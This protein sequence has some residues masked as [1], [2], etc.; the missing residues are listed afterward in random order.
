MKLIPHTE[1]NRR[2]SQL[3]VVKSHTVTS[4]PAMRASQPE[5]VIQRVSLF[6]QSLVHFL[7]RKLTPIFLLGPNKPASPIHAPLFLGATSLRIECL[8]AA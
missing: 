6:S 7:H 5:F 3:P 2:F 8:L 1:K 4:M